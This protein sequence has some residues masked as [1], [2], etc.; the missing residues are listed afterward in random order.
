MVCAQQHAAVS[1]RYAF[2]SG[3]KSRSG[4]TGVNPIEVASHGT[5]LIADKDIHS[6]RSLLKVLTEM[7][8]DVGEASTTDEITRRLRMVDYDSVLLNINLEIDAIRS[9]RAQSSRMPVFALANTTNDSVQ[10]SA[11][12]AGADDFIVMP[13]KP[14]L[15]AARVRSSI[16][17]YHAREVPVDRTLSIGDVTLDPIRRRVERKGTVIHLR[18]Q[19][20]RML[21]LLMENTEKPLTHE[22]IFKALWGSDRGV[23]R[24]SRAFSSANCGR[25][26][27]R[28]LRDRDIF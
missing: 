9:V 26:L 2:R 16:R 6:R 24:P 5:V 28:I 22:A 12:D 10:L 13:F 25:S 1:A 27:N 7:G 21:H 18:P 14:S 17:R 11:F 19:E 20:F 8:F 23:N 4:T 15:F 3:R